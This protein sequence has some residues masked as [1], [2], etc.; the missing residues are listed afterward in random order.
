MQFALQ[1]DYFKPL[2]MNAPFILLINP[3]IYDFAAYD[4][5]IKPLG[6]LS[7]AGILK[8]AGFGVHVIDCL[9]VN[10]PEMQQNHALPRPFRGGMG[11]GHFYQQGIQKP[12]CLKKIPRNYKRYGMAPAIFENEL[13]ALPRPQAVLVTSMMTYWYPGVFASI[14]IIKSVH[15]HVPVVLGGIYATLCPSHA[16][17]Y[18]GADTVFTGPCNKSL[19]RILEAITGKPVHIAEDDFFSQPDCTLLSSKKALPIL[20]SRGCPFRCIYCASQLLHP[21]FHQKKPAAIADYI[22]LWQGRGET[23]DFVFY[24][25]ALLVNPQQHIIPLLR[26]VVKRNISVRFHAPNGLHVRNIDAELAELMMRA[27]FTTL[28][29]GLETI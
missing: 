8:R 1:G 25:D 6:L 13:K 28:R 7:I 10:H 18:S 21:G 17:L 4:L 3:W 9:D 15:P 27:G 16:R 26:E 29:L 23:T 24:D 22:E 12:D 2:P 5:W 19:A 20:S 14:K 11:Q